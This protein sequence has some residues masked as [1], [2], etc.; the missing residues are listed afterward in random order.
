MMFQPK[1]RLVRVEFCSGAWANAWKGK[2]KHTAHIIP[3]SCE[4]SHHSSSIFFPSINLFRCHEV[5]CSKTHSARATYCLTA[6]LKKWPLYVQLLQGP[7][8]GNPWTS[9]ICQVV[10]TANI[11]YSPTTHE[12]LTGTP[13]LVMSHP[14]APF[15]TIH[16]TRMTY[17]DPRLDIR[18]LQ[19]FL[20]QTF[21]RKYIF[22]D[23]FWKDLTSNPC[24]LSCWI[25]L[26]YHLNDL[27]AQFGRVTSNVNHFSLQKIRMIGMPFQ[28]WLLDLK[29]Q[30]D[31]VTCFGNRSVMTFCPFRPE[32]GQ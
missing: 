16:F 32:S 31:R 14:P 28:T 22:F 1:P 25:N 13:A 26:I 5:S 23:Y 24:H 17:L 27:T 30:N 4:N 2:M 6:W 20:T 15:Y 10:L 11:Q 7:F 8:W 12:Q 18:D 19:T 29:L 3:Q 9:W 21:K